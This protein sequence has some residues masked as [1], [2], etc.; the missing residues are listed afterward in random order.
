MWPPLASSLHQ[1]MNYLRKMLS[2]AVER[3]VTCQIVVSLL[4]I[5][6]KLT[7]WLHMLFM[8]FIPLMI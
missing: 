1:K 2:T 6:N 5:K 4:L 7:I 3:A 8:V